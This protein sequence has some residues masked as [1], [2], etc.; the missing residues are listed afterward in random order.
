[1]EGWRSAR[2]CGSRLVTKATSCSRLCGDGSM[3]L[4]RLPTWIGESSLKKPADA[5]ALPLRTDT[6]SG[7]W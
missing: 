5:A 3:A 4:T 1:M 7:E 6:L 2:A